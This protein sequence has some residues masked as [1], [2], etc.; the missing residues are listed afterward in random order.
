MLAFAAT[1]GLD[2]ELVV[3]VAGEG[4]GAVTCRAGA[5]IEAARGWQVGAGLLP[6]VPVW[7]MHL[8]LRLPGALCS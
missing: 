1:W 2:W 6:S 5:P 4:C 3:T 7:K 8:E